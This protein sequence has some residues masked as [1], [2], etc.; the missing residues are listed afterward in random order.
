MIFLY[1]YCKVVLPA[2]HWRSMTFND[3]TNVIY[4]IALYNYKYILSNFLNILPTVVIRGKT[5][6]DYYTVYLRNNYPN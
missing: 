4:G 5:V 1:L 6:K 2:L 3:F